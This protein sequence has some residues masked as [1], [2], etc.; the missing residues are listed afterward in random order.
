M[1]CAG[2]SIM[3]FD[4]MLLKMKPTKPRKI[5]V[6]AAEDV[7]VL[8]A[9][10]MGYN[11]GFCIPIL[12]GSENEIRENA[13]RQNID[14][15]N[16]EIINTSN[17]VDAAHMA[18]SL[19]RD[20]RADILMKGLI[21]TADLL[22]VV[23]H[24]ET[25]IR[26]S[27]IITHVAVLRNFTTRR[28]FI[29]T[30]V[31]MVPY[32]DLSAKVAIVKNAVNFAHKF[33]N[34]NPLVAPLCS[35][36]VV[37]PMMPATVDAAELTRMNQ[38][39]EI[40]GCVIDG[41]ISFDLATSADAVIAKGFNSPAAG[42]ADILLF[43]NIDAGNM[44]LKSLTGFGGFVFGGLLMGRLVP[45]IVNSRSDSEQSKLFSIRCACNV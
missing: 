27:G 41:P 25:G 38:N 39:G 33:G 32:P 42:K 18:V 11:M 35:V 31:A 7:A 3:D 17:H 36:E 4:K 16:W 26:G 45:V 1:L 40:T 30:D 5:A 8:G 15:S 10:A 37:N 24:R 29:L 44:V 43:P 6:A 14:I 34:C 19:V 2:V 23:L 13:A 9:L 12:C 20:G 22:R 28:Q 21:K